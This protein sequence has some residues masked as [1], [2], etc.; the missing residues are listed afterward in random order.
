MHEIPFRN[1]KNRNFSMTPAGRTPVVVLRLRRLYPQWR[2]TEQKHWPGP[3]I[4]HNVAGFLPTEFC[5]ISPQS[6]GNGNSESLDS[7]ILNWRPP[8][9]R[10]RHYLPPPPTLIRLGLANYTPLANVLNSATLPL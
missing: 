8:D 3:L 5:K 4:C 2:K 1:P 6:P 10:L 7:E 9:I